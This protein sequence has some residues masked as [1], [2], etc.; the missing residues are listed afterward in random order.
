MHIEF[1]MKKYM[2][3]QIGENIRSKI[4]HFC[5]PIVTEYSLLMSDT[6]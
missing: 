2:D 4:V 1:T 5:H 6:Y 3:I